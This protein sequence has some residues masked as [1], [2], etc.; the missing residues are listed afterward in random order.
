MKVC[1]ECGVEK[2]LSEF[3]VYTKNG[4]QLR[5]DCKECGA[6]LAKK[7]REKNADKMRKYHQ[8]RYEENK[9]RLLKDGRKFRMKRLYGVTWEQ[10]EAMLAQGGCCAICDGKLTSEANIDHCHT[11]G[12][13]R[14][15]LC[16]D[17]NS[18]LG[19]LNDDPELMRRAAEYIEKHRE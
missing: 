13:V 14:A 5:P 3:N 7:Y 4:G 1:R 11:T 10:F 15:L 18:G 16:W 8:T 2:P 19:L 12:K 6:K 9:E 17:C